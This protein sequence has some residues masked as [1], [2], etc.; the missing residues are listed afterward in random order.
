[1]F[2]IFVDDVIDDIPIFG[3]APDDVNRNTVV[4]PTT[5][6]I[7]NVIKY[8]ITDPVYFLNNAYLRDDHQIKN[9][10]IEVTDIA[11]TDLLTWNDTL[12]DTLGINY[13]NTSGGVTTVHFFSADIDELQW[14]MFLMSF[15]F[16]QSGVRAEA[17]NPG[18]RTVNVTV[19][20]CNNSV[21]V[22]TIINV[23]PL[24]PVIVITGIENITFTEGD[25]F[26]LLRNEFPIAV[27]QDQDALFVSLRITLQ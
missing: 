8:D 18:N 24:P 20:D 9:I 25:N 12:Q 10:T 17:R 19:Q 5:L 13:L 1:M 27:E 4:Y 23:L 7:I 22:T 14:E 3:F 15:S 16:L 2:Q 11:T 26:I 21:T 6:T